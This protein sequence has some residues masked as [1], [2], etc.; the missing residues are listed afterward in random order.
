M[1]TPIYAAGDGVIT[2][3]GKKSGYGRYIQ[4]KHSPTLSTA[5]GHASA[6]A[7]NLRHGSK[8]RQGQI[9]AYVG[10]DGT[11]TGSHL[12]YEVKIDGRHVNPVSVKTAP[13]AELTGAALA[14]FE[15]FK[16]KIRRALQHANEDIELALN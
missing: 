6:F 15:Q 12:H 2:E 9:I 1:G 4:I 10:R 11:A 14:K 13:G 8:V 7:K 5:Y 3:L 16:S